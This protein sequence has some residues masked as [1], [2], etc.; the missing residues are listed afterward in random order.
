MSK[1]FGRLWQPFNISMP[2]AILGW[3]VVPCRFSL[4][5]FILSSKTCKLR[6]IIMINLLVNLAIC[7]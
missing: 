5:E 7:S 2:F 1:D 4:I 3:V 6:R